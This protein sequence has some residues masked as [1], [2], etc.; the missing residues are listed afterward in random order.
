MNSIKQAAEFGI[1][2][3]GHLR[4][5]LLLL[6]RAGTAGLRQD[7]L[8]D[9]AHR[10]LEHFWTRLSRHAERGQSQEHPL[11]EQGI[12]KGVRRQLKNELGDDRSSVKR[13]QDLEEQFAKVSGG[14]LLRLVRPGDAGQR[15]LGDQKTRKDALNARLV[16]AG[17]KPSK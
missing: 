4:R 10:P 3:G 2:A 14:L 6:R 1:V 17:K 7:H 12:Q 16:A 8:E 11:G 15:L 13:L 9:D 5:G